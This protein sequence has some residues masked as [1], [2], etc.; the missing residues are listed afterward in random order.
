M[1]R[2]YCQRCRFCGSLI[3]CGE[4]DLHDACSDFYYFLIEEVIAKTELKLKVCKLVRA[5][6]DSSN[7]Q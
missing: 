2:M 6:F 4:E 1:R 3:A 5:S 7:S